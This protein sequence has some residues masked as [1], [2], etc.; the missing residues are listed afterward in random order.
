MSSR[1]RLRVFVVDDEA[2]ARKKIIRFLSRDPEVEVVG[3]A[4]NGRDAVHGIPLA[5]PDLLFLDVQMPAMDGFEVIRALEPGPIPKVVF[6]TAHD[7]YAIQAFDVHAFG[8]L[9]KPFDQARFERVLA[10]AKQHLTR[11]QETEVSAQLKKLLAEVQRRQQQP[12]RLLVEHNQRAFFL[13]LN[14][15]D[16]AE[17]ER[18]YL[19]LHVGD[20]AYTIRGTIEGLEEKVAAS[21]FLR[22]NRST[23]V[24]IEF[25]RELES[26]FHG[27]YKVI[28][29]SGE[30]LTWTRRYLGKHPE[31]LQRL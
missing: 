16:W 23:L 1:A 8:Y 2:P 15:I 13:P 20:Q 6:V 9:L 11:D 21:D 27:E 4:G 5:K 22:L 10:D 12:A 14:Q 17:S 3:E 25:I 18:N 24:R 31:L 28:L 29:K 30:K 7:E 19:K 26:W